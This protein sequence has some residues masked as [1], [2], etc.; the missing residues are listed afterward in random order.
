MLIGVQKLVD[1]YDHIDMEHS[2]VFLLDVAI[3]Q[4]GHHF[5][6]LDGQVRFLLD[7]PLALHHEEHNKDLEEGA[8][9]PVEVVLHI[10]LEH[11]FEESEN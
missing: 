3:E 4:N 1:P 8:G 5:Q 9:E 6:S 10:T 7:M 2:L 11:S